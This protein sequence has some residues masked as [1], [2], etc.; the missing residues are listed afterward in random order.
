MCGSVFPLRISL[1][2]QNTDESFLAGSKARILTHKDA[3]FGQISLYLFE[4]PLFYPVSHNIALSQI[5]RSVR[6]MSLEET[7]VWMYVCV[8]T[9]I[10]LILGW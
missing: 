6:Q 3:K 9:L 10:D 7:L 4:K 2:S 8:N 5:S 1:P